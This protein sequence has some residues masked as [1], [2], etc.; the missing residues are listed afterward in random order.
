MDVFRFF[1]D[2]LAAPQRPFL[3]RTAAFG[4]PPTPSG[5]DS[6]DITIDNSRT[7]ERAVC[8]REC[9]L[10]PLPKCLAG[11]GLRPNNERPSCEMGCQQQDPL[12][13]CLGGCTRYPIGV[14]VSN[15]SPSALLIGEVR[16]PNGPGSSEAL[17]FYDSV[18]VSAG[19]SRVVIGRIH[20]RRD[21]PGQF[22]PRVFVV[23]F[24]A[25]TIIVYDPAERRVD[26][27]IRTGRGPHA[28]VMD[29]V[30]PIAYVGHFTDSY[31]GL[32]DLDQS[33]GLTY[34]TIV[35]TVGTPVS[36]QGTK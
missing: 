15:R 34:G 21:P 9:R 23:C 25:R 14:Y 19:P 24:D 32:V 30:A 10:D 35:A 26:G 2:S 8:E 3:T 17:Q 12:G 5:V 16:L 13:T 18:P 31:L 6:R 28:L 4:L 29:P 36:P 7:T 11:C 1:D 22:R 20:D 33:H 27:L